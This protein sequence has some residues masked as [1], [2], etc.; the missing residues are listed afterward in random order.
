MA[1]HTEELRPVVDHDRTDRLI[2]SNRRLWATVVILVA[3]LIGFGGW[4]LAGRATG[5]GEPVTDD[6]AQLL[7]AHLEAWNTWDGDAYLALAT[8]NA[9]HT[10]GSATYSAQAT[11]NLIDGLH[12]T[13][14]QVEVTGDPI[15][16]GEGPWRIVI[17]PNR[18][19]SAVDQAGETGYS[20]Y[21]VVQSGGTY[22]VAQHFWFGE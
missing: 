13:N 7:D 20:A 5:P 1:I 22:K 12:V 15:M 9:I 18:I 2:A 21:V 14:F 3:A 10:S 17:S 11:A 16:Y 4:V 19:S 8:P 6:I